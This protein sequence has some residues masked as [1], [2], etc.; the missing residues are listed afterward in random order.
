MSKLENKKDLNKKPK[1]QYEIKIVNIRTNEQRTKTPDKIFSSLNYKIVDN[2]NKIK[3]L[4]NNDIINNT[5]NKNKYFDKSKDLLIDK[6]DENISYTNINNDDN[7]QDDINDIEMSFKKKS[8]TD[9]NKTG[10]RRR[11][12]VRI[13]NCYPYKK[14]IYYNPIYYY[15]KSRINYNNQGNKSFDLDNNTNSNIYYKN[16]GRIIND[17]IYSKKNYNNN[18]YNNNIYI[19]RDYKNKNNNRCKVEII[20]N[21]NKNKISDNNYSFNF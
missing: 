10:I 9:N 19:V 15:N 8:N 5:N 4:K 6:S 7:I 14:K 17:T 11:K 12:V 20:G 2:D 3:F 18:L 1:Y 13:I 16:S 21:Y